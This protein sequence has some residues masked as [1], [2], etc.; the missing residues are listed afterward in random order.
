MERKIFKE[1]H[2]VFRDA[3]RR[4]M[5]KEVVPNLAQWDEDGICPRDI[6]RK[7]GEQGF[8]CP[9][10]EEKYGG[11]E[12]DFLYSVVITEELVRTRSSG[13]AVPMHS[14]IIAPYIDAF[15][16]DAQ[17]ERWL[18]GCV[19]GEKILAIAMT[20]PGAGSDLA[21]IRT[22]AIR[23]G[24]HYVVNGQKTFV[25]NGL[26]CDIVVLAV[27]TDPKADPP[28][29]G[30]SLLV[31]EE[32]TPGFEK[33]RKLDKIGMRS[34]DTAEHA[35]EDCKVPVENLLGEE[36]QGFLFLMQKLQPER[37]VVAVCAQT[38][39]EEILEETIEY[40]KTR[41]AFGRPISKFQNTRFKL[42]EMATEIEIGRAFVD[43]LIEDHLAGQ[44]VIKE[45]CMAKW[46]VTEM[47]KRV[48]DECLQLHGGYGYMM[49]YP[50]AR[51]FLDARVQTIYAGTTEI[52][53]E[54]VGRQMG[55]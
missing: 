26:L 52:M 12:A 42:A 6:W 25:S 14:D 22:T 33:G 15:G 46:W 40:C 29:T 50:I 2:N 21:S 27:K 35:Y 11:S 7:M 49:E 30:V 24:D 34:Q 3:V 54:I 47:L 18:P 4:F 23:E 37:L 19:S 5:Q 31:V 10:A 20:E 9:W 51:A 39:A 17:K 48:A 13:L 28:H 53:K 41:E 1:E 8:L 16:T 38:A 36:G 32:G 44:I 55:L 45:T 43:R